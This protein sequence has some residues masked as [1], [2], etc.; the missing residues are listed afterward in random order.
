MK[1]L[2]DQVRSV[3]AAA[4]KDIHR[5]HVGKDKTLIAGASFYFV[6]RKEDKPISIKEIAQ[7]LHVSM[8]SLG[9]VYRRLKAELHVEL[10]RQLNPSIYISRICGKL[11]DMSNERQQLI[12]K[13]THLFLIWYLRNGTSTGKRPETIAAASTC[14]IWDVIDGHDMK[15]GDHLRIITNVLNIPSSTVQQTYL[16]MKRV[17]SLASHGLPWGREITMA[18]FFSY[19]S[20]LLNWLP[21]L[22]LNSTPE[23]SLLSEDEEKCKKMDLAIQ[24]LNTLN[25][26][27]SSTSTLLDQHVLMYERHLLMGFSRDYLLSLSLKD[28]ESMND[29]WNMPLSFT[30]DDINMYIRPPEEVLFL[31]SIQPNSTYQ[32]THE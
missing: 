19:A 18:T 26:G 2:F 10:P 25:E 32:V 20:D 4:M 14:L 8:Y 12:M 29:R 11:T 27:G 17:W 13:K 15:H 28:L 7:I 30:D 22:S 6:M 31:K 21:I 5:K 23:N 9:N 1:S 3:Y 24:H 16:D